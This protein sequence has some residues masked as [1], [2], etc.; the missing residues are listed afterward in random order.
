MKGLVGAAFFGY[1]LL[2]LAK[3]DSHANSSGATE[4]GQRWRV[5]QLFGSFFPSLYRIA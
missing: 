3:S 2:L 4:Q 1:F 5:K